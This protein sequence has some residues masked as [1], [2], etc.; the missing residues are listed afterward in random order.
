M[1]NKGNIKVVVLGA[2]VRGGIIS[3]SMKERVSTQGPIL[4]KRSDLRPRRYEIKCLRGNRRSSQ[5]SRPTHKEHQS[6]ER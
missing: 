5:P 3:W 1:Q 6:K 4:T 2:S